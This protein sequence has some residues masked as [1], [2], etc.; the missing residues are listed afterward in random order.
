M[1]RLQLMYR[2]A[3]TSVV[4]AHLALVEVAPFV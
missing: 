2:L 3:S 1:S 4:K